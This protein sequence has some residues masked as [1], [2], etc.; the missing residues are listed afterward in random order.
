MFLYFCATSSPILSSLR[1]LSLS[2]FRGDKGNNSFYSAKIFKLNFKVF[3]GSGILVFASQR[4][5]TSPN[6]YP[7]IFRM[8]FAIKAAAKVIALFYP[9]NI[10]WCFFKFIFWHENTSFKNPQK[11][12]QITVITT[13]LQWTLLP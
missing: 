1:P 4:Q 2:L 13:S 7:S 5:L 3:F 8:N 9:A 12:R 11:P 10:F 6:Y